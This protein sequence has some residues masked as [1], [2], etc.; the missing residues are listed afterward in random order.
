MEKVIRD[1]NTHAKITL[2]SVLSIIDGHSSG[3]PDPDHIRPKKREGERERGGLGLLLC[4]QWKG[5]L[6]RRSRKILT[7]TDAL[8]LFRSLSIVN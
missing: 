1:G 4:T 8:F 2:L 5:D 7:I 6:N 3:S